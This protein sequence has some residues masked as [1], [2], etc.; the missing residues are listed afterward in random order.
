MASSNP[1]LL[2]GEATSPEPAE[3]VAPVV[4]PAPAPVVEAKPAH[5]PHAPRWKRENNHRGTSHSS[6]H[7]EH[8]PS[9]RVYSREWLLNSH[10]KYA[11]PSGFSTSSSV[12]SAAPKLPVA[13]SSQSGE[14]R[15]PIAFHS[16]LWPLLKQFSDTRKR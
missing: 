3:I 14:V 2:L 15:S 8:A 7:S 10:K 11:A 13:L 4:A 6:S 5:E 1:F 9:R 12:F 16:T